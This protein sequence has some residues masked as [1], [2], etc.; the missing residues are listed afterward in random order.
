MQSYLPN[1][2][3]DTV[4]ASQLSH[5]TVLDRPKRMLCQVRGKEFARDFSKWFSSFKD[6]NVMKYNL[7]K[8]QD[9]PLNCLGL[10]T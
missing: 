10:C 5:A 7:Y 2:N 3:N 1:P 6:L 4:H 8:L 9:G